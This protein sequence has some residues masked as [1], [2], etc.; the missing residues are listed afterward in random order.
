MRNEDPGTASITPARLRVSWPFLSTPIS[1]YLLVMA[2]ICA[3]EVFLIATR[4]PLW[5][6]GSATAVLLLSLM[7]LAR[8]YL[9]RLVLTDR[10]AAL[11]SLTRRIEIPWSK[12]R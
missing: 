11:V 9:R 3:L 7:G 10:S 2:P 8:G 6:Q 4:C 12:V 1:I 5:M